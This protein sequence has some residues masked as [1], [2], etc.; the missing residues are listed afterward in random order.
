[1]WSGNDK[2]A[3]HLLNMFVAI[4]LNVMLTILWIPRECLKIFT[5]STET[6]TGQ[7]DLNMRPENHNRT[8]VK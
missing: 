5:S 7:A 4:I 3:R 8:S 2:V 6:P 1:M